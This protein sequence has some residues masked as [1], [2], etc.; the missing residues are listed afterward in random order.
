MSIVGARSIVTEQPERPGYL[1]RLVEAK[2]WNAA[3]YLVLNFAFGVLWFVVLVTLIATGVG[4]LIT[5]FGAFILAA[6]YFVWRFAAQ[7]E[8]FRI[9]AFF[10]E[11]IPSPPPTDRS[12]TL[13][14]RV[15]R[16]LANELSWRELFYVF[17]LFPVGIAELTLAA[18]LVSLPFGMISALATYRSDAM[19]M[20]LGVWSV[21]SL[22]KAAFVALA[23]LLLILPCA[24]ALVALANGH[25]ALARALLSPR[26]IR[27]LEE[28]VGSLTIS[29]TGAVDAALAE[30]RR[31]ERDL[32]DGAQQRLVKLAMDLGMAREQMKSDPARAQELIANAHAESKIALAELRD[33]VRGIHPAI[34][35][36]RGLDAALSAVAD[37]THVPVELDVSLPHR[38]PEAVESAAYF[39]VLEAL[40]NVD[41]HASAAAARASV[42]QVGE[43]LVIDVDDNG[44][45]GASLVAGGGLAGLRD[46]VAALD[47]HISVVS[48]NGGPTHIHAE[49]PCGLSSPKTR[50]SSA[51][52]S[53][54]S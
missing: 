49:I 39:V 3:I 2:P 54:A 11:V 52:A 46:R 44:R 33:L 4:T 48:P 15:R 26:G 50:L 1:R 29:R 32:H 36:D 43:T 51:K 21:D 38:L 18:V 31:I 7:L 10:D 14:E 53:S 17:L 6:A 16:A 30:R 5:I 23:G 24:S 40:A 37:R 22:P 35:T 9:K 34:L 12:G 42:K 47:G 8:R 27:E 20:N 13:A 45:G 25:R 19:Q 41:K 28:R